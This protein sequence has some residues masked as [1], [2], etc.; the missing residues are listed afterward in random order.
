MVNR[1]TNAPCWLVFVWIDGRRLWLRG[2][3]EIET[4]LTEDIIFKNG[5]SGAFRFNTTNVEPFLSESEAIRH[6]LM[7]DGGFVKVSPKDR[8]D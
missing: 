8:Y 1:P 4:D 7:I 3:G 2:P 5:F 6:A